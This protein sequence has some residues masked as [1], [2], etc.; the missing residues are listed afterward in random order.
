MGVMT[1]GQK[2][3]MD[4]VVE[5]RSDGQGDGPC[6]ICHLPRQQN[7]C[8]TRWVTELESGGV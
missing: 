8:S 1:T 3:A 6:P 2:E 5:L 7:G 4:R